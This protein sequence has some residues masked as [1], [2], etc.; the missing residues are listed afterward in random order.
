MMERKHG[1]L[2]FFVVTPCFFTF[3]N[4]PW[5]AEE[6]ARSGLNGAHIHTYMEFG[7]WSLG[8]GTACSAFSGAHV[9]DTPPRDGLPR[10]FRGSPGHV[11]ALLGICWERSCAFS[12]T[13]LR[14]TNFC[15]MFLL[16]GFICWGFDFSTRRRILLALVLQ[17]TLIF[18]HHRRL[19][20]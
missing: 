11:L 2:I 4:T 1:H 14:A 13:S 5:G 15:Y 12:A 6:T 7:T 9:E 16:K 17:V 20:F 8:L 18:T 3:L 19:W 10:I